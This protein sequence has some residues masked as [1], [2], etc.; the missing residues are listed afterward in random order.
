MALVT[1]LT[2]LD[3]FYCSNLSCFLKKAL[4]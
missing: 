2:A 4:L 3:V 1:G